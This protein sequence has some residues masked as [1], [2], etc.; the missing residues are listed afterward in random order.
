MS[1]GDRAGP[2]KRGFFD[3]LAWLNNRAILRYDRDGE[4]AFFD[5]ASFPW[6]DA[7]EAAY[8]AIRAEADAVLDVRE[9]VPAFRDLSPRQRRLGDDDRWR[10]FWLMFYGRSIEAGARLCPNTARAVS[11]V[12]G[13]RS[14]MF[15]ILEPGREIP[16]HYGP[17]KALLRVH[18]GVRVPSPDPQTCGIRVDDETR[19]WE[20]GRCMVF[21]DTWEHEAWNRSAAP[22]VV[23]FIDVARPL[24]GALGLLNQGLQSMAS[25]FAPDVRVTYANAVRHAEFLH[26]LKTEGKSPHDPAP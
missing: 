9:H 8:P 12:P 18:M 3:T 26:G 19:G 10:T 14:A 23:L 2:R 4:V 25:R 17:N 20:E 22:R 24:S 11:G 6:L 1:R 15:S 16:P 21:D 7:L 13:L 5:R